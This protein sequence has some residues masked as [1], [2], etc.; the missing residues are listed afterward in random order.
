MDWTQVVTAAAGLIFTGVVIPLLNAAF[1]WLKSKTK[2]LGL[3]AAL[4]EAQ[5][6]ADNVVASLQSTVV[7]ALKKKSEN[8]KLTA[9]EAKEV[10]ALA[11]KQFISDLSE[12]S[13]E[14]LKNGADDFA[15][16]VA[17]LIEARLVLLKG[18]EKA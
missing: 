3:L 18:G 17:R 9:N 12:R 11:A 4:N 6:V 14:L 5:T 1:V 16:Y 7:D 13:S 8:G 15:A 10:A 2:N